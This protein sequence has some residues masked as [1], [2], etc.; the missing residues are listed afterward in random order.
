M[1]IRIA[2][3]VTMCC[4][5]IGSPSFG[6]DPNWPQWR[7]PKGSG[8]TSAGGVVTRWG[9]D[10]NVKWR[11][12]LPE[13]GNSTPVVWG[14]QVFLTQPLSGSKERAL[15]CVDRKTGREQWRRSVVYAEEESTTMEKS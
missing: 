4:C 11:I 2:R 7:G 6:D 13:A 8:K 9:P 14:D 15:I 5:V 3:A 10:Q 12:D 1:L